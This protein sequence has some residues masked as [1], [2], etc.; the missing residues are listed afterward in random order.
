MPIVYALYKCVTLCLASSLNVVI[1]TKK[2]TP[3]VAAIAP[4]VA[5][6]NAFPFLPLKEKLIPIFKGKKGNALLLATAGA[7]AA[8]FGVYFFVSITTLSEEAKQRVTHLYN[9][10]TM[11]IAV[12]GKIN[13]TDQDL[14]RIG[15]SSK[16]DLEDALSEFYLDGVFVT[17]QQMLDSSV[18][19]VGDDVTATRRQNDDMS[20]DLN[21]SGLLITYLDEDGADGLA[22]DDVVDDLALAVNLAGTTDASANA[23]YTDG[24]PFFYIIMDTTQT[25]TTG[26]TKTIT[27]HDSIID[28]TDGGA[29]PETSVLLPQDNE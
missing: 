18:I 16:S 25:A 11:G 29:Q 24:D 28:Q 19:I 8:T 7:I 12:E 17:L 15:S 22:D 20:Y 21:N 9:A 6:S 3:N 4:A 1:E 13:G 14:S 5:N 27:T 2:Y 10:Y 26:L 23:P